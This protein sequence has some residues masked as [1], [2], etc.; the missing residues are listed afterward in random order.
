MAEPAPSRLRSRP[1]L[2][3]AMIAS[4]AATAARGALGADLRWFGADVGNQL[5][6]TLNVIEGSEYPQVGL[7]M[8]A[9]EVF[10]GPAPA[11]L[12]VPAVVFGRGPEALV[13]WQAML[14][15][16]GSAGLVWLGWRYLCPGVGVLAGLFYALD[17]TVYEW[18]RF[19]AHPGLLPCTSA[20][21]LVATVLA[22]ERRGVFL[23]LSGIVLGLA[24]QCHAAGFVFLPVLPLAAWFARRRMGGWMWLAHAGGFLATY[25]SWI[26]YEWAMGFPQLRFLARFLAQPGFG[27]VTMITHPPLVEV[28]LRTAQPALVFQ[29]GGVA[30]ALVLLAGCLALFPGFRVVSA[31]CAATVL[32]WVTFTWTVSRHT[33]GFGAGEVTRFVVPV[34]PA[35]CIAAATGWGAPWLVLSSSAARARLRAGYGWAGGWSVAG[36]VL[37]ALALGSAA[38]LVGRAAQPY[39]VGPKGSWDPLRARGSLAMA[40]S[41]QRQIERLLGGRPIGALTAVGDGDNRRPEED[42]LILDTLVPLLRLEAVQARA[43]GPEPSSLSPALVTVL[44]GISC[45]E[46][47]DEVT[48]GTTPSE[49]LEV[50]TFE[51]CPSFLDWY[52]ERRRACEV[53]GKRLRI[54]GRPRV[55]GVQRRAISSTPCMADHEDGWNPGW[56]ASIGEL[57]AALGSPDPTARRDAAWALGERHGAA[58]AAIDALA[59]RVPDL[60]VDVRIDAIWALTKIDP[61]DAR[62]LAA[63]GSALRDS[64]LDV[65]H[66]AAL[67]LDAATTAPPS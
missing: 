30:G 40:E 7:S 43:S 22:L 5:D 32:S 1:W 33:P 35:A 38:G 41:V 36:C 66:A 8:A 54:L 64:D 24:T 26:H 62:V 15:G 31:T 34:V 50:R 13:T 45:D 19:P 42:P 23:P 49:R 11:Y 10:L 65:A 20:L 4:F 9:Q 47:W 51:S 2:A 39:W 27:D 59:A 58:R 37:G 53:Y 29:L 48:E 21:C 56:G 25:P 6:D 61:G 67:A 28:V 14:A 18:V 12:M 46:L 52:S 63:V 44:H 3:V 60:D 57:S 16:L 55:W 17:V